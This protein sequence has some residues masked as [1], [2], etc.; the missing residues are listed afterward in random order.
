MNVIDSSLWI[1]YFINGKNAKHIEEV[2]NEFENLLVPVVVLTE[3]FKWVLR[4]KNEFDALRALSL[5][6]NGKVVDITEIIAINAAYYSNKYKLPFADSYIYSTTL[7][8]E[9]TLYT[10]DKHFKDLPNVQHFQK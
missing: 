4:E 3:V 10:L 8:Y 9:A 2:I 7:Y 1:E 5:M 6:K